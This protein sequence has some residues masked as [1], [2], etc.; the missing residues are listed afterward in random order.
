[1]PSQWS[2]PAACEAA[3]IPPPRFFLSLR[4]T[5]PRILFHLACS[6]SSCRG[7]AAQVGLALNPVA[8][9]HTAKDSFPP[10][11]LLLLLPRARRFRR[12]FA[13]RRPCVRACPRQ[14][15]CR[16]RRA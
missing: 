13:T 9:L 6:C 1:M 7:L 11:L 5:P 8:P 3:V 14:K 2:L 12:G 10:G 16:L 15:V 4:S